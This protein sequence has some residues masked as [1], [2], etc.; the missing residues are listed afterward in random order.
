LQFDAVY[1]DVTKINTLWKTI[2]SANE[3]EYSIEVEQNT[4]D[5][6]TQKFD[7]YLKS[8]TTER[9]KDIKQ[10]FHIFEALNILYDIK[11]SKL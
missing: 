5:R 2:K 6:E 7:D 3:K 11:N 1:N 9:I 8:C 10:N 4:A